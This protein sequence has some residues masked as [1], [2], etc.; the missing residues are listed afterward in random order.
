[1]DQQEFSVFKD[2]LKAASGVLKQS[3]QDY[4]QC[5]PNGGRFLRADGGEQQL[6][7]ILE[8]TLGTIEEMHTL[9]AQALDQ[10]GTKLGAMYKVYQDADGANVISVAAVLQDLMAPLN[11]PPPLQE[12]PSF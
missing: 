9:V 8:V 12:P 7:K 3:A 6:N 5:I 1:M 4:G 11:A 10:H 2:H